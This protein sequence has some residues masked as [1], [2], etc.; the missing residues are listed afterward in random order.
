MT[1]TFIF[2]L[3]KKKIETQYYDIYLTT[4]VKIKYAWCIRLTM[5]IQ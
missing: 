4:Q 3:K 1:S 5:A 2:Y